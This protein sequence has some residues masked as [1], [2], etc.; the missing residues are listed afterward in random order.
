MKDWQKFTALVLAISVIAICHTVDTNASKD[1]EL[2]KVMAETQLHEDLV[3][4][5]KDAINLVSDTVN[6]SS[7]LFNLLSQ[8][9]GQV[10]INGEEFSRSDLYSIAQEKKNAVKE[11]KQPAKEG[12]TKLVKG[13]FILS[14]ITMSSEIGNNLPKSIWFIET[15]TEN[16]FKYTPDY[17]RLSESA[18]NFLLSCIKG[19][20]V[21]LEMTATYDGNDNLKDVHILS[22]NGQPLSEPELF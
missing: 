3:S 22:W 18:S 21:E 11:M 7:N 14:E 1:I 17:D 20:C 2:S 15:T 19:E 8:I 6:A 4:V 9:D 12:Y 13:T 5:Q 10:E 16:K